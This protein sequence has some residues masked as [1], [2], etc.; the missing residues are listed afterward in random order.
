MVAEATHLNMLLIDEHAA[1]GIEGDVANA[2]AGVDGVKCTGRGHNCLKSVKVG[3][4]NGPELRRSN[5]HGW[6]AQRSAGSMCS[7]GSDSDAVCGDELI[8]RLEHQRVGLK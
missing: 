3:P 7:A 8:V 5:G 4:S 6:P 2:D 1:L